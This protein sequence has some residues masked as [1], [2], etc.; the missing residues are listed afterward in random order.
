LPYPLKHKTCVAIIYP[1][2]EEFFVKKFI[3][4]FISMAMLISMAIVPASAETYGKAWEFDGTTVESWQAQNST[5]SVSEGNLVQTITTAK[6]NTFLISPNNLGIDASVYKYL[7]V[8]VKNSTAAN[9]FFRYEAIGTNKSEFKGGTSWIAIN[10][11][12]NPAD[13]EW[14]EYCIDLSQLG[15]DWTGTVSRFRLCMSTWNTEGTIEYDYIRLSDSGDLSGCSV[16]INSLTN[17]TDIFLGET[18]DLTATVTGEA[19]K[20]EYFA[21]GTSI[22]SVTE[23]PYALSYTPSALGAYYISAKAT[24]AE[25]YVDSGNTYVY[26]SDRN[27]VENNAHIWEFDGSTQ[28]FAS[29]NSAYSSVGGC[30]VQ[31]ITT[32]KSNTWLQSPKNLSIDASIYKYLKVRAK[33]STTATGYFRFEAVG[34]NKAEYK[35]SW[36]PLADNKTP[37]DGEWHEYIVD[38]SQY[39]TDWTGTI[40]S[41]RLCMSAWNCAGTVEFDYIRLSDTLANGIDSSLVPTPTPAPT[42]EPEIATEIS[43]INQYVNGTELADGTEVDGDATSLKAVF[44]ISGETAFNHVAFT[45]SDVTA[46]KDVTTVSGDGATVTYGIIVDAVI[47]A[48]AVTSAVSYVE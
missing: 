48:A 35:G 47:E 34:T 30:L 10:G 33:N 13:G 44:T 5:L 6:N 11:N 21:N 41:F 23:A 14:H 16:A 45:V 3:S 29:N 46:E 17:P 26:V 43:V 25:G 24:F 19:T 15:T 1:Q 28:S 42:A 7:K 2:K 12:S 4:L 37:N 36:I 8:R 31:T 40:T 20:V 38:L 9:G 27:V 22:G 39:G 18:I 32:E